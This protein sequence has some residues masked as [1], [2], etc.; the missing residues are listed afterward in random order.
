MR[1]NSYLI[2]EHFRVTGRAK[3]YESLEPM[4]A[5]LDVFLKQ[6]NEQPP[7]Q[8]I[9]M[10]GRTPLQAFLDGKPTTKEVIEQPQAA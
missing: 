6:Y 9:G 4:Q 2:D 8:G 5:E 3:F 10:N 1:K 7:H